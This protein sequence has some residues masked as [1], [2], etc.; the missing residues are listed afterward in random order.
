MSN[1]NQVSYK[2]DMPPSGGYKKIEYTRAPRWNFRRK[3]KLLSQTMC[4]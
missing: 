3:V 4:Q 2:Q 1:P